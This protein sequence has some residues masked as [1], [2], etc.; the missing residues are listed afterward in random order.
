MRKVIKAAMSGFLAF[1]TLCGTASAVYL[2]KG[3]KEYSLNSKWCVDMGNDTANR[4]SISVGDGEGEFV[5]NFYLPFDCQSVGVNYLCNENASLKIS[6]LPQ[7][8]SLDLDSSKSSAALR[9][10]KVIRRSELTLVL[11]IKG[12]VEISKIY[13]NRA[14]LSG[15]GIENYQYM[16]KA[17]DYQKAVQGSV[18]I[19]VN[20]PVFIV[21]GQRRYF[22]NDNT[23]EKPAM[24]DGTVYLPARA[25]ALA[26]GYY[27]EDIGEK[28]YLMLRHEDKEYVFLEG[29][30]YKNSI[31]DKK[32]TIPFYAKYINGKA[33]LPIR[34]FAEEL[35][36]KVLWK[37]GIIVIDN[38]RFEAEN[39]AE[40]YYDT[41]KS[42]LDAFCRQPVNGNTYYVSKAAGA[43]D[44][45][46]GSI[47]FPF[48]T[49]TKAGKVAQAGDTVIIREGVYRETFAPKNDGTAAAPITFKAM[50]GE[51]VVISALEE[52][53]DFAVY[54][55]DMYTANI[56]FNLGDGRNMVFYNGEALAEARYPNGPQI[57]M[58]ETGEALSQLFPTK[59]DLHA[60]PDTGK[61]VTSDTL[62]NQPDNYWKGATVVSMH[63]LGWTLST[64][65]VLSSTK[66]KVTVGDTAAQ[67]WY[68]PEEADKQNW[69]FLTGH[70]NCLDAPGEWVMQDKSLII[71]PPKDAD[72]SNLRFEMKKRQLV[73]D[74][75]DR[76]FVRIEGVNTIGGGVRMNN[77][78]M[79]MLNGC[80]LRY[81]SHYIHGYDQREGYIYTANRNNTDDAPQRGEMGIY[82]GGTDNI[83]VN[84]AIDHSAASGIL[85]VGTYAYI[86]NNTVSNCG[87]AG[88][89]IS[90]IT[91]GN[92][93][94]NGI[95]VRKGGFTLYNNTVYNSGRSVLNIQNPD[96]VEYSPIIPYEAAYNDFHDG[97][98]FSLDTGITYEY[99][100]YAKTDKQESSMH[101]N[102]VYY[103]G[104]STNPYSFAIYHDGGTI[105]INTYENMIF[106]TQPGVIFSQ[107]YIQAAQSDLNIWNNSKIKL[108][109]GGKP[110]KLAQ[111][112]FLYGKP[113]YA[114]VR[115]KEYLVNYNLIKNNL[116]DY[117]LY[118]AAD[119]E[120]SDGVSVDSDGCANFSENGQYICFKDVDFGE[121]GNNINIVF[122]ADKYN[123][124]DCIDVIVGDSLET[125]TIYSN[126][127]VKSYAKLE[128]SNDLISIGTE[129]VTGKTNVYIKVTSAKSMRIRG[130]SVNDSGMP[131]ES[132]SGEKIYGGAYNNIEKVGDSTMPPSPV[133]GP[134][135]VHSYV[136][137]T[138]GGTI[139]RYNNVTIEKPSRYLQYS[140]GTAVEH[141]DQP[142]T[143]AYQ[144]RGDPYNTA[145][146]AI[147]SPTDGFSVFNTY[148]K[149]LDHTLEPGTYDI[150]VTF[151]K[152]QPLNNSDSTG[153]CNF[154]F[155]GF[156]AEMP[157]E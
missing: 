15:N 77:S 117:K 139:L 33:Y 112:E 119:A 30:A 103:T 21:R 46:D 118:D 132:H 125:G 81:I 13:F 111:D 142:I 131:A 8:I 109:I 39:I 11:C 56:G 152:R 84:S 145:I 151:D 133:G 75:A 50:E 41:I 96:K 116:S 66:G 7:D 19:D 6:G 65:K 34:F 137:N 107:L 9:L 120:L 18:L 29:E 28:S 51:K 61:V 106:T 128:S 146:A 138:W 153:T 108:A 68:D 101:N 45:N 60:T 40:N 31:Y 92:E 141:G 156:L 49:L 2:P 79:C 74:I 154:W 42:T 85:M 5:Y 150:Y 32:E 64:G 63:G 149:E 43:S 148:Y 72:K 47:D 88:G 89:Y 95:D 86:E 155:F 129:P 44:L 102:Y 127:Y 136:K 37:D 69:A 4:D 27:C 122:R 91:F 12:N 76:K 20:S 57:E 123:T 52:I 87:Y 48:K 90:G 26:L 55:D 83:I 38:D 93:I 71:I 53:T 124:N 147:Y 114:G 110:E 94:Y 97:V 82:V 73:I 99:H 135:M 36:K 35:G 157:E 67:W 134:D 113:Y 54:K 17:D 14:E 59:G 121:N 62:L 115:D 80:R 23:N 24:I 16:T 144:K 25:L 143:I 104:T 58:S 126:N 70:I 98:L 1:C 130:I 3:D 22:D 140:I 10:P 78:E 105:G 100:T